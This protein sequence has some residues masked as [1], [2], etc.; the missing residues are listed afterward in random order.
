MI[1]RNLWRALRYRRNDV[2]RYGAKCDGATDD[3]DALCRAVAAA[4]SGGVRIPANVYLRPGPILPPGL[5]IDF[6]PHTRGTSPQASFQD[7]A[8]SGFSPEKGQGR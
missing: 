7:Q 1:L 3:T 4:G 2:R 8:P 6:E 5:G